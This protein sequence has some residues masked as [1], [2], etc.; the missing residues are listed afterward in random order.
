MPF[1]AAAIPVLA[2]NAGV[3]GTATLVGGGV[4]G[5]MALANSMSKGESTPSAPAIAPLPSAPTP[6]AAQESAQ[7]LVE[8]Q[9]RMRALA[10]GKTLLTTESPVLGGTGGKTLLGA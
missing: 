2:A 7:A 3:L 10:G 6:V 9:R 1:I 8:K 5:G 4:A